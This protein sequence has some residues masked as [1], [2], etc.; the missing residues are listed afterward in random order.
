[1]VYSSKVEAP[2]IEVTVS[3]CKL[4]VDVNDVYYSEQP[5]CHLHST[6]ARPRDPLLYRICWLMHNSDTNNVCLPPFF[7]Q[8]RVY[9]ETGVYRDLQCTCRV[10][11]TFI[12]VTEIPRWLSCCA[13][14]QGLAFVV[15]VQLLPSIATEWQNPCT[16]VTRIADTLGSILAPA[17]LHNGRAGCERY[18]VWSWLNSL[19]PAGSREGARA[20][21]DE[22]RRS[23]FLLPL[24]CC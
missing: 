2:T 22:A 7:E 4:V 16:L 8:K 23:L 1:M 6:G 24:S 19:P 17:K 21:T 12:P 20:R 18:I 10:N 3:W 15:S 9:S 14:L 5:P 11:S 13:S